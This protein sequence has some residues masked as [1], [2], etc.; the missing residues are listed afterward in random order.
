MSDRSREEFDRLS[1]M[2]GFPMIKHMKELKM[3]EVFFL[4]RVGKVKLVNTPKGIVLKEI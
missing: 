3:E 1:E 2:R 4:E